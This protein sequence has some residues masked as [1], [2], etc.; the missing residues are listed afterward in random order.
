MTFPTQQQFSRCKAFTGTLTIMMKK[1]I[2]NCT[3]SFDDSRSRG[4]WE[5]ISTLMEA[6]IVLLPKSMSNRLPDSDYLAIVQ[7]AIF[8]QKSRRH[9]DSTRLGHLDTSRLY[10]SVRADGSAGMDGEG[11]KSQDSIREFGKSSSSSSR[12]IEV[13]HG[14]KPGR[15]RAPTTAPAYRQPSFDVASKFSTGGGFLR[16]DRCTLTWFGRG[17]SG[18]EK[19]IAST[20]LYF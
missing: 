1:I 17:G 19:L 9:L 7:K 20:N 13:E 10:R 5:F 4:T 3:W 14:D 18:E 6:S 11:S 12:G 16:Q 8:S 15:S 2:V